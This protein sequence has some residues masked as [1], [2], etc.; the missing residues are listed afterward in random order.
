MK[1]RIWKRLGMVALMIIMCATLVLP[2]YADS[3]DE[4]ADDA[5][6]RSSSIGTAYIT[7]Q[8]YMELKDVMI[9]QADDE[10]TVSFSITLHNGD[11]S[12]I[13]FI[14]YWV[15][16][17]TKSGIK[18]TV[19]L[20]PKD[21]DKNRIA[22]QTSQTFSFYSKVSSA[23]Q[24]NDLEFKLIKWDFSGS[25]DFE[26]DVATIRIPEDYQIVTPA[27]MT[28]S[29]QINDSFV[30][31]HMKRSVVSKND[32]YYLPTLT[33]EM[34]NTGSNT[35]TL[36]ELQYAIRT[37]TGL[38]YPLTVTGLAKDTT[39]QPLVDKE[40]TLTGSIP[41]QVG[42]E[43]WQLII[44]QSI[45]AG[46]SASAVQL[47]IA[48]FEMPATAAQDVSIGNAYEFATNS[49]TYTATLHALYRLPWEDQ[50]IL[51][52]DITIANKG[53]GALPIPEFAGYFKLDDNV[54]VEAQAI[55]TDKVIGIQPG[56][57]IRVH[58]AGKIP[59]TYEFSTVQL[60][61]Q[62]KASGG[63][64]TAVDLLQFYH[65][66]A[67]LNI[68]IVRLN[69]VYV[70]KT[71]GKSADF[72]IKRL[73]TY[74]G[75]SGEVVAA[76][77]LIENKEKRFTD[78]A[79][80][81]AHF[82][83]H[84]GIMFPAKITALKNKISPGGQGVLHVSG[85]MPRGYETTNLQLIVGEAA[86][87]ASGSGPS[88]GNDQATPATEAY[89]NAVAYELP[90]EDKEPKDSFKE[91]DITPYTVSLSR[92]GASLV[93]FIDGTLKMEFTY[94]L[95]K[96]GLLEVNNE[97]HRLVVELEDTEGNLT[98]SQEYMFERSSSGS[99]DN[100][101]S[102]S[103][104]LEIGTHTVSF[105]KTDRDLSFKLKNMKTYK[106]NVYE[107]IQP[108]QKKLIATKQL[109]WFVYSD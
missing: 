56:G 69:T 8:S 66:S 80:L 19:N 62:E 48:L 37:A 105:E 60:F 10:N 54:K 40:G 85:M 52:A 67:L 21:K 74:S 58:L 88:V 81:V 57:E 65:N 22:S 11:S 46:E 79:D 51:T 106:M 94:T 84:D 15:R 34:I 100:S 99:N 36:P 61:L 102:E 90:Q 27:G 29:F 7:D 1:L 101:Q 89:V 93:N 5:V 86:A 14:N 63:S 82:R 24:L 70:F 47:P 50:D 97:D 33:L 23:T 42:G 107:Q 4:A 64:E 59:Y 38:V 2:V 25:G 71:I 13:Q 109:P 17:Q 98:V 103:N 55:R 96:N 32:T 76:Q 49:G 12:E 43:G 45:S 78:I 18:Y 73:D 35:L 39:I 68:P 75:K 9:L 3:L 41:T 72:S 53:G 26:K 6:I 83:T 30:E 44:M 87:S 95:D 31:A 91:L 108:G 77:L 16:L 104:V 92:L 28:R 20:L